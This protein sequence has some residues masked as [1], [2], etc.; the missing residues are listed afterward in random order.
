MDSI[1]DNKLIKDISWPK[2]CLLV[3]I[4]RGDNEIIPRGNVKIISG[5][6]IVV[7]VDDHKISDIYEEITAITL[8]D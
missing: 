1:I 8:A 4:K 2:D 6:Y 7:L 3:A 5:D